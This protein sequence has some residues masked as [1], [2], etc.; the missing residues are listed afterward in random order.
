M[1]SHEI[2]EIKVSEDEFCGNFSRI[3][4][5]MSVR[6]A[7]RARLPE[8]LQRKLRISAIF[9]GISQKGLRQEVPDP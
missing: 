3:L 7:A 5:D 9:S 6:W 8:N 2:E 4:Q 1:I